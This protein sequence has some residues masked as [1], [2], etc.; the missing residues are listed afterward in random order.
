MESGGKSEQE[1]EGSRHV[2]H[3]RRELGGRD[4]LKESTQ[5]LIQVAN[6]ERAYIC[7]ILV[8]GF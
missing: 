1:M 4:V 6:V 8:I 3:T 2:K 5:A 7:L